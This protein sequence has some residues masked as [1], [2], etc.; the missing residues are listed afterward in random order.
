M[1]GWTVG[2]KLS[3]VTSMFLLVLVDLLNTTRC[4]K[5][6]YSEVNTYSIYLNNV[7]MSSTWGQSA[8]VFNNITDKMDFF[9]NPKMVENPSETKRS[10]FPSGITYKNSKQNF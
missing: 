3:E 6:L 2:D 10:A 4:G 9:I 5:L 8:W 7:I 1:T